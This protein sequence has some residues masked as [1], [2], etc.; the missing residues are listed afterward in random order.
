MDLESKE[1]EEWDDSH[2][3]LTDIISS[4]TILNIAKV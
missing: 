3:I 1:N 4:N 2:S